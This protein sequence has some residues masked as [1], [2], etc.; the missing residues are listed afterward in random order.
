[1]PQMVTPRSNIASPNRDITLCASTELMN[2]G[3]EPSPICI[4]VLR[5]AP[6]YPSMRIAYLLGMLMALVWSAFGQDNLPYTTHTNFDQVLQA[7]NARYPAI[8]R[9]SDPGTTEHR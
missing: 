9:V 2:S 1:M 4:C 3:K 8:T 5:L 7:R 6:D